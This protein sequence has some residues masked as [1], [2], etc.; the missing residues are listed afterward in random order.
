MG[1]CM[2][3]RVVGCV[4]VRERERAIQWFR[5]DKLRKKERGGG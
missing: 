4:C 2:V 3:I 5:E 1:W